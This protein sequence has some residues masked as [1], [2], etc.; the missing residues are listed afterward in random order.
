MV[1]LTAWL[2]CAVSNHI[3]HRVLEAILSTYTPPAYWDDEST[4]RSAK[5]GSYRI[6]CKGIGVAN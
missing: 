5:F 2:F 3:R 4:T 6:S 1:K